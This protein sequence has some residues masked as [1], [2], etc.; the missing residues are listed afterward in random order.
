MK[1]ETPEEEPLEPDPA[2]EVQEEDSI[3]WEEL[4]NRGDDFSH[5]FQYGSSGEDHR[6]DRFRAMVTEHETLQDSLKWQLELRDLSPQDEELAELLI[7]YI[8]KEG[9]FDGNLKEIAKER[10]TDVDHLESLLELIQ[11]FDPPGVAGRSLEEVLLIQ[12]EQF[13]TDVP[14]EA[15]EIIENHLED[16]QNRYYKKISKSLNV[17]PEVVQTTADLVQMCEP[18][19]GRVHEPVERQ[20]VSPDV[21]VRKIDGEYVIVINNYDLPPLR[22]S[23]K[24]RALLKSG[25]SETKEYV[26]EKLKGAL[27]IIQCVYQRHKT[28]YEVSSSIVNHQKEFFEEG[29]TSLKPLILKDVAEDIGVHESTVSRAV[30]NKYMQ[31]ERGLFPFKFFFSSGLSTTDGEEE[32]SSTAIKARIQ[33][34]VEEEDKTDPLSDR[35]IKDILNEEGIDIGRRTISKY[36]KDMLI[37]PYRLRKRISKKS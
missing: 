13:D 35:E 21:T 23:S 22:I 7:S 36:R 11:T 25:D 27:W 20:Y 2:D 37:P 18:R 19:P 9:H 34:L 24:Y 28:L 16:L 12:L 4:A 30:Q 14:D 32:V 10:D 33:E 31:T 1:G 6:E 26:K 5:S 8:N 29:V 3:N 17:D 15:E